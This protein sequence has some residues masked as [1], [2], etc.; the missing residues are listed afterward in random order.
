MKARKL[1]YK[2]VQTAVI[3]LGVYGTKWEWMHLSS[4]INLLCVGKVSE[5]FIQT[6]ADFQCGCYGNVPDI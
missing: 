6:H 1:V 5:K 2:Y 3:E 4:I